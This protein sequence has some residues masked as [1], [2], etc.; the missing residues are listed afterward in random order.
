MR[1]LIPT[2]C[3]LA[4]VAATASAQIFL[5]PDSLPDD[6]KARV[7][8]F[9][10]NPH[11]LKDVRDRY[12]AFVKRLR[13]LKEQ[14][15]KRI[16][17]EKVTTDKKAFAVPI[18]APTWI[19]LSGVRYTDASKN[20][21]H[22]DFHLTGDLGGIEVYYFIDGQ[23]VGNCVIYHKVDTDFVALT[24]AKDYAKRL[25]WDK[26][27]FEKIRDWIEKRAEVVGVELEKEVQSRTQ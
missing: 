18:F 2:I 17:G 24:S 1:C 6:Q 7:S 13:P 22:I 15:V 3:T 21:D 11:V 9:R 8:L 27:R 14:D 4:A 12:Q 26:A 23:S 25:S 19:G 20:K 5:M 16:F 10:T